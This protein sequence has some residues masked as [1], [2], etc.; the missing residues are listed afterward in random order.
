LRIY[1]RRVVGWDGDSVG[2]DRGDAV[3]GVRAIVAL[4]RVGQVEGLDSVPEYGVRTVAEARGRLGGDQARPRVD[5]DIQAVLD[6][7]QLL[8]RLAVVLAALVGARAY[9]RVLVARE[10]K[11]RRPRDEAGVLLGVD[12]GDERLDDRPANDVDEGQ[13]RFLVG[14]DEAMIEI[15]QPA[16]RREGQRHRRRVAVHADDL[17]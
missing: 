13:R 8:D 15:V 1:G 16:D 4:R 9:L 17:A 10:P 3:G 11:V 14:P 6:V 2:P 7:G 12:A 5:V